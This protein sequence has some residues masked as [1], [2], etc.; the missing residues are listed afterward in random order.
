MSRREDEP[1]SHSG[2][3]MNNNERGGRYSSRSQNLQ[4][5][6]VP[7][8]KGPHMDRKPHFELQAYSFPPLPSK[9]LYYCHRCHCCNIY[10]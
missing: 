10:F 1:T 7:S 4:Q 5:Q 9:R 2:S 3:G 8:N 6:D